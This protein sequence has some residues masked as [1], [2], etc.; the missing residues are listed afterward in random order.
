MLCY[1]FSSLFHG[2]GLVRLWLTCLS[3][4]LRLAA[5]LGSAHT[6]RRIL[7]G[8][9]AGL[10]GAHTPA[11][12]LQ[13]YRQFGAHTPAQTLTN[14]FYSFLG[15]FLFIIHI[16]SR[17]PAA[18]QGFRHR[19]LQTCKIK[20]SKPPKHRAKTNTH[21]KKNNPRQRERFKKG[22]RESQKLSLIHI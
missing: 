11:H 4:W 19:G 22:G 2:V 10:R 12:R 6:P 7:S 15:R 17:P 20:A 14:R 3:L 5:F 18:T 21:A 13:F 8:R 9:N 16:A 1:R